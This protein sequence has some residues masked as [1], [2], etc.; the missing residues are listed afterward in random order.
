MRKLLGLLKEISQKIDRKCDDFVSDFHD[1][2]TVLFLIHVLA[3]LVILS[4]FVSPI[5]IFQGDLLMKILGGI[6]ILFSPISILI[7][8]YSLN[9]ASWY[10]YNTF[11]NRMSEWFD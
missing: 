8:A 11:E 2:L 7:A 1:S 10:F 5:M 9:N 3:S 6:V 4:L